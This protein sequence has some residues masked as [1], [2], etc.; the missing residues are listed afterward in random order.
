M[1]EQLIDVALMNCL[2]NLTPEKLTELGIYEAI[3]Y[4]RQQVENKFV[5]EFINNHSPTSITIEEVEGSPDVRCMHL[6]ERVM[7]RFKSMPD[8]QR[9]A[10]THWFGKRHR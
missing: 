10:I 8:H 2:K 1:T 3:E 7:N 5:D 9:V 4:R 6:L